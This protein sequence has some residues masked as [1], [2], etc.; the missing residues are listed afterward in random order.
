MNAVWAAKQAGVKH[1][2]R[3]SAIGAAHD[4]PTRNGRLHALSDAELAHSGLNWTII[5][6]ASF[7]QNLIGSVIDGTLYGSSGESRIGMIDMRDIADFA[8]HVLAEPAPHAGRTYTLTGPAGIS[9]RDAA[10]E[11]GATYHPVTPAQ[12][13]EAMRQAGLDETLA[14]M[15]AEYAAAFASGWGSS[16]TTDYADVMGRRPRTFA[17]FARDML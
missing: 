14:S 2:V 15:G 6:P 12:A 16:V 17:D 7:M 11:V 10:A 4:A 5:K 1:V 3:L 8:A 13:Y 9:L